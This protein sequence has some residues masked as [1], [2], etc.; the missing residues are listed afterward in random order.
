[1]PANRKPRKKHKPK[2][3]ALSRAVNQQH[4]FATIDHMLAQLE[5][6]ELTEING[7]L[8]YYDFEEAGYF[9][10]VPAL[11]GWII[12]V[13]N[14][15][16][17]C[18]AEGQEYQ[19][20]AHKRLYYALEHDILIESNLINEVK[21]EIAQHKRTYLELTPEQA[22]NVAIKTR[23]MIQQQNIDVQEQMK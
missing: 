6:G 14:L 19:A 20:D 5:I 21:A 22:R 17:S 18:R 1:M 13:E 16:R 3:L 4:R 23:I 10:L 2:P 8:A 11:G 9:Q 7:Q 12:Y 15:M